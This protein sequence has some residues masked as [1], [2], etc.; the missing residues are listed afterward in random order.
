MNLSVGGSK[1]DLIER[2]IEYG[3]SPYDTT[4]KSKSHTKRPASPQK[5]KRKSS[6]N[7]NKSNPKKSKQS[8]DNDNDEPID[9]SDASE[10]NDGDNDQDD[11]FT[12]SPAKKSITTTTASKPS[13]SDDIEPSSTVAH[14]SSDEQSR[15]RSEIQS[16]I[17]SADLNELTSKKVIAQLSNEFTDE[18]KQQYKP[19]LKQLINEIVES[20]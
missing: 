20:L 6:N 8:S 9:E 10:N 3:K 15:V 4:K 13:R 7:T 17:T 1:L 19:Y 5:K 2:I 18:F 14:P 16:I 11:E 12:E